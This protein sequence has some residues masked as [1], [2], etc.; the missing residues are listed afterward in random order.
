MRT[1][2]VL[3]AGLLF[4]TILSSALAQPGKQ[5]DKETA[6]APPQE[7]AGKSVEQWIKEIPSKDRSKGETAIQT[8]LLFGPERAQEALPVLIAELKRHTSFVTVDVSIRVNATLAVGVLL[9]GAKNPE[10]ELVKDAVLVL[11]RM[12]GDNQEIVKYRAAEALGKLGPVARSSIPLLLNALRDPNTWKTRQAA[13]AALGFIAL[14]KS[15]VPATVSEGLLKAL[16]DPASQVR[17]A[18]LQSLANLGRLNREKKKAQILGIILGKAQSDPEASV[19]IWAHMGA[20]NIAEKVSDQH[21]S[22]IAG[23]LT[24]NDVSGRIQAAQALSIIGARAKKAVPRLIAALNDSHDDI[25]MACLMALAS[26]K[27]D[28]AKALPALRTLAKDT[29]RHPAICQA[30]QH[31][32][33][34]ISGK[35]SPEKKS[36]SKEKAGD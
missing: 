22:A 26:M 3:A 16:N 2:H 10:P 6:N 19:R 36:N 21:V 14:D 11:N 33:D 12:L 34:V 13:A 15:D 9:S 30:A 4:F 5:K 32:I 29:S 35:I 28:A 7:I 31:T 20:M 23:M 8:V 18:A 17:V 25:V 1:L 27:E 24:G